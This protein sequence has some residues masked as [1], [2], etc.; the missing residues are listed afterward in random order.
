MPELQSAAHPNGLTPELALLKWSD[1]EAVRQLEDLREYSKPSWLL[2][3]DPTHYDMMHDRWRILREPLERAMLHRLLRGELIATAL[4]KPRRLDSQRIAVPAEYWEFLILHYESAT[5]EGEEMELVQIRICEPSEILCAPD[6]ASALPGAKRTNVTD[7][8]S[9]EISLSDSGA[10][11]VGEDVLL[12]RGQIQISILRQLVDA[13]HQGGERLRTQNVLETA[14]TELDSL[15]K[16]FRK[17]PH[18]SR[19]QNIIKQQRG[20][21]WLE[22]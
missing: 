21:C 7:R 16:V 8:E 15:A 9:A 10:L 22:L 20:F 19:L 5:A 17:N 4:Q 3:G 13:Y 1:P 14:G 6:Q 2:G 18:W 11:K 12:F